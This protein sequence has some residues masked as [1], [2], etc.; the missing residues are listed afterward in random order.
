MQLPV[1]GLN[2]FAADQLER[3]FRDDTGG[4]AYQCRFRGFGGLDRPAAAPLRFG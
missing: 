3:D 2:V 4:L 1:Q